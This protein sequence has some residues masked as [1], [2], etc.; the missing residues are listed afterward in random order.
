[1]QLFNRGL[2]WCWCYY[3]WCSCLLS[4]MHVMLRMWVRQEGTFIEWQFGKNK[5]VQR[6]RER[7]R[8]LGSVVKLSPRT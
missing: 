5:D 7:E 8:L 2:C 1:M 4:G 3:D 6:A